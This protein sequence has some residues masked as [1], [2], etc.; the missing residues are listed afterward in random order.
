MKVFR[1]LTARDALRRLPF[2]LLAFVVF[3]VLL[4]L[5]IRYATRHAI[6]HAR[7]A[8]AFFDFERVT[9]DSIASGKP[10]PQRYKQHMQQ[11]LRAITSDYVVWHQEQLLL[12]KKN[13]T[14]ARTIPKLVYRSMK[15]NHGVGDVIRGLLHSYLISVISKRMF[16]IDVQHPF[17]LSM[18]LTSPSE[19]NFSY[20]HHYFPNLNW[21]FNSAHWHRNSIYFDKLDT[22]LSN[23]STLVDETQTVLDWELF[24]KIPH[25]YPELEISKKLPR[26]PDFNPTR[27]EVV[28]FILKAL[29]RPST[30]L[31]F[32]L[33][34]QEN[35]ENTALSSMTPLTR[36]DQSL[37]SKSEMP[38]YISVHARVGYGFREHDARFDLKD[39]GLTPESLATCMAQMA[40]KMADERRMRH[41]S[42]FFISSDTDHFR[43]LLKSEMIR[44]RPSAKVYQSA[45]VPVHMNK[46]GRWS[47]VNKL[48]NFMNTYIDVYL[49]SKGKSMLFIRS[50]FSHVALWMGAITD[51]VGIRLKHCARVMNGSSSLEESMETAERERAGYFTERYRSPNSVA[52]RA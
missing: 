18:V 32:L 23:T 39:R 5:R 7:S 16:F 44:L 40:I 10:N 33:S 27:E 14:H 20:D 6:H 52:G 2:F 12:C 17:P 13:A 51:F 15:R 8:S 29:F 4:H 41:P 46:L 48:N 49:L 36:D 37:L 28:P 38:P 35:R 21:F 45:W 31:R 3:P 9:V 30:N 43:K 42:S 11:L 24:L 34:G 22:A 50:G 47:S 19:Y 25:L 26:S 1:R